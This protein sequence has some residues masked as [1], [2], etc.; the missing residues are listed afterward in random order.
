MKVEEHI[1]GPDSRLKLLGTFAKINK[2]LV[3]CR[4]GEIAH[5]H[6]MKQVESR[7]KP[8]IIKLTES[9]LQAVT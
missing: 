4:N 8:V 1:T 7:V 3:P 9:T 2:V 6:Q 5:N